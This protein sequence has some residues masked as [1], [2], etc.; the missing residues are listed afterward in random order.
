MKGEDSY[1]RGETVDALAKIGIPAVKPLIVALKD[2][3][4]YVREGA[5]EALAKMGIPAIKPLI[6]ALKDK[7]IDVRLGAAEALGGI[8]EDSVSHLIKALRDEDTSVKWVAAVALEIIASSEA[9]E[10]VDRFLK[11]KNLSEIAKDY[12]SY[13]KKGEAGTEYLLILALRRDGSAAMAQDFFDSGQPL[14]QKAGKKWAKD[15]G[16]TIMPTFS[17]GGSVRWGSE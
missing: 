9:N 3:D 7:D 4:S 17:G 14:L 11:N 10:A 15:Y 2:E 8:G 1:A 13:I 6:A 16:Y 12:K 5:A